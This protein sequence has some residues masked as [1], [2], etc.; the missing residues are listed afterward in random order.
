MPCLP[1]RFNQTNQP[2]N[3]STVLNQFPPD[4]SILFIQSIFN[5][6]VSQ[7]NLPLLADYS[8]LGLWIN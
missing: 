7:L 3:F 1:G 2:R 5:P 8:F 6:F 4:E